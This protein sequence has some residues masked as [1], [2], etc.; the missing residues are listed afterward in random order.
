MNCGLDPTGQYGLVA[1]YHFDQGTVGA[2]NSG[3]TTL[4]DA[5]GNANNGT[6][7]NFALTGATSNWATGTVSGTCSQ[8]V[9]IALAGTPG[10]GTLSTTL[11]VNPT[12]T[13][14]A[15]SD[16]GLIDRVVPSGGTPLSGSI[17]CKVTIDATVQ[18]YS[19]SPYIQRHYDI[20]PAV[21]AASATGTITLYYT[22]TEF[23][24]YNTARGI[25]PALPVSG[26]DATGIANLRITQYHGT[27]TAPGNYTGPALLIDP[28][29]GNI[30]W[31]AV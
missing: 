31:N 8:F 27:G 25:Y 30:I 13:Y 16:C 22:Q 1:L 14:Y 23:D 9:P 28:S 21:N 15:A 2:D 18:S 7:N 4:I 12:G 5:S 3:I 26:G 29:D 20:E 6:L 11:N 19:G 17:T 10:G 24:N